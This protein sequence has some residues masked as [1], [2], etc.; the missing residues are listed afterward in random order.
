M[1]DEFCG[2]AE[3][4]REGGFNDI[5]FEGCGPAWDFESRVKHFVFLDQVFEFD[6]SFILAQR[7]I[8]KVVDEVLIDVKRSSGVW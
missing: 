3:P 7:I 2:V 1:K 5:V 6:L 8:E 4:I